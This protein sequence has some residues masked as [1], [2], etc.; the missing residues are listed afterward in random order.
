MFR[1]FSV[2]FRLFSVLF[3]LISVL[4]RLLSVLFMFRPLC[5]ITDE[6]LPVLHCA[7][8]HCSQDSGVLRHETLGYVIQ[9]LWEKRQHCAH[10]QTTSSGKHY[11]TFKVGRAAVARLRW[12]GEQARRLQRFWLLRKARSVWDGNEMRGCRENTW[13]QFANTPTGMGALV[14]H[15]L[16]DA[17]QWAT[18]SGTWREIA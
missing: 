1:L 17:G 15:R 8:S 7:G 3:R 10:D 18:L 16:Q 13:W 9:P 11:Y 12:L 2:L 4:F 6:W 14:T 5:I